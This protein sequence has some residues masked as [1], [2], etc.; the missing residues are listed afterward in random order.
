M[1]TAQSPPLVKPG[2][3]QL[4]ARANCADGES[5]STISSSHKIPQIESEG[6]E[7]AEERAQRVPPERRG[8]VKNEPSGL[9]TRSTSLTVRS[10]QRRRLLVEHNKHQLASIGS[11]LAGT[12][13]GSMLRGSLSCISNTST[14]LQ[15][16][17]GQG[18]PN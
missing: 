5:Q 18:T 4:F 8:I 15:C 6:L 3:K 13:F 12:S 1:F 17:P 9:T 16:G 10:R 11:I 14:H 7:L 2:E